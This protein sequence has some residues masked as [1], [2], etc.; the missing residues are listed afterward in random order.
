MD[1]SNSRLQSDPL[2]T[3]PHAG[4]PLSSSSPSPSPSTALTS[5]PRPNPNAGHSP[6]LNPAPAQPNPSPNPNPA[7]AQPP[8][9]LH[10][11]MLAYYAHTVSLLVTMLAYYARSGLQYT[12][13]IRNLLGSTDLL[14][15]L[16]GRGYAVSSRLTTP[17]CTTPTAPHTFTAHTFTTHCTT[18]HCTTPHCATPSGHPLPCPMRFLDLH[19]DCAVSS[20]LPPPGPCSARSAYRQRSRSGG[21]GRI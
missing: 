9:S 4:S 10:S 12:L 8:R 6:N 11:T 2:P 16:L 15:N 19:R 7:P 17:H 1:G 21:E 5:S 14:T 13:S 18:A 20:K 3:A